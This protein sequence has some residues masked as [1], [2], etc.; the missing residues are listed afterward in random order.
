MSNCYLLF[1][2][3]LVMETDVEREW[4]RARLEGLN[5]DEEGDF[6]WHFDGEKN[7]AFYSED[8]GD[9][10]HVANFVQKFLVAFHP[11]HC[12]AMRWAETDDKGRYDAYGGGAVFVTAKKIE[13]CSSAGWCQK[14]IADFRRSRTSTTASPP[15]TGGR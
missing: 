13:W 2:D 11:D 15:R 3:V 1:S 7:L 4:A 9:T 6:R 12:W 10:E 5:K 8:S 14:K